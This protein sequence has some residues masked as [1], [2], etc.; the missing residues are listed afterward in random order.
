MV[1][2]A[3][4]ASFAPSSASSRHI[5]GDLAECNIIDRDGGEAAVLHLLDLRAVNRDTG[6][7]GGFKHDREI[8]DDLVVGEVVEAIDLC[9]K[10][11]GSCGNV[12][13]VLNAGGD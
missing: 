13:I 4:S 1:F 12:G 6:G 7:V 8:V 9:G 3:M 5:A 2:T 10:C 11:G